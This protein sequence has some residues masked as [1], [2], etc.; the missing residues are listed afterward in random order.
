MF[1]VT[2]H[3]KPTFDSGIEYNGKKLML[4]PTSKSIYEKLVEA[5]ERMQTEN[6]MEQ[7]YKLAALLL[8]NNDLG[9]QIPEE[10]VG[11]IDIYSVK[12][13]LEEYTLFLRG[14]NNDPN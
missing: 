9:I 12:S 6:A 10:E 14:M 2:S 5:K 13:L 7:A 3:K 11:E 8:N 4:L 1:V